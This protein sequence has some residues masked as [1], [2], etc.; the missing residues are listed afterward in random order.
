MQTD[1]LV[2]KNIP[3]FSSYCAIAKWALHREYMTNIYLT[4][5]IL[6]KMWCEV[7]HYKSDIFALEK[8]SFFLERLIFSRNHA[9]PSTLAKGFVLLILNGCRLSVCFCSAANSCP[10]SPR[11][12]GLSS[13]RMGRVMPS[14]L[15]GDNSQSEND[16]EASGGDSPKVRVWGRGA[17]YDGTEPGCYMTHDLCYWNIMWTYQKRYLPKLQIDGLRSC[18]F[19]YEVQGYYMRYI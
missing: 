5:Y 15:T 16:K 11:G 9:E 14:D 6:W 13:Y 17:Q 1:L 4:D 18:Y 7:T 3:F 19:C 2:Y 10:S 12:A 8:K